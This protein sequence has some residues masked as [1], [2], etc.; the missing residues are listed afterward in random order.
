MDYLIHSGGAIGSD[1]IWESVGNEYNIP[2]VA[3]S[4]KGHNIKSSLPF[5]L[6]DEELSTGW[7]H[8]QRAEITLKRKNTN[9]PPYI[10]NLFC[11]NWF[12]VKNSETTFAIGEFHNKTRTQVKGGTGW[13]VQMSIDNNHPVYFFDQLNNNWNVYVPEYTKFLQIFTIPPFPHNFAG[14]GTRKINQN[15][16]NAIEN[17]FKHNFG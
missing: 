15:G 3:Y 12:Q 8:V 7:E 17:I 1:S 14:I 4:F 11:R 16:I 13:A 10:K 5:V 2:T 6:T 9:P